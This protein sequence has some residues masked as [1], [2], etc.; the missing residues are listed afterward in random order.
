MLRG[1]RASG[2]R[3]GASQ[4][5]AATAAA[6]PTPARMSFHGIRRG[7]RGAVTSFFR[8]RRLMLRWILACRQRKRGGARRPHP[9]EER[10]YCLEV[11]LHSDH[12]PH[13]VDEPV[14]GGV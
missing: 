7:G 12:G 1:R 2:T 3:R 14:G 10:S 4:K 11:E 8:S 13:R 6:A 9:G 5:I